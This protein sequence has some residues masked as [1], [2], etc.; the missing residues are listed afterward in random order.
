MRSAALGKVASAP[1]NSSLRFFPIFDPPTWTEGFKGLSGP[2]VVGLTCFSWLS[3]IFI[4]TPA[5]PFRLGDFCRPC[6]ELHRQPRSGSH[7]HSR[8]RR[9]TYGETAANQ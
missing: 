4:L 9:L 8:R 2:V 3:A 1:S 7:F 5:L 6:P